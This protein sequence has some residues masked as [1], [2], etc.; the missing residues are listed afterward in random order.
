MIGSDINLSLR[1]IWQ[2]WFNFRKGK[3]ATKEL[4][5]FQFYLEKNIFDLQCDLKN[6]TYC[7]GSYRVFTVCDN[8][9]RV[10]S[11]AP[12]RDRIVH[13]L[14]Y[15]Y[16]VPIFD[17]TFIF[18]AWSCRKGKGLLVC[19]ERTQMF[20]KKNPHS[21]VWR[22][23]IRKFFD[24]VNQEILFGLVFRKVKCSKAQWL[25]RE[26][27]NSFSKIQRERERE[28]FYRNADRQPHQPNIRQYL[29]ERTG[30]FCKT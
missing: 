7:H 16:L 4:H 23:D 11:V 22:A 12:I 17:K 2:S 8:K 29:S 25:I 13:R 15:D 5:E 18:D 1:N 27:V 9:K 6:G 19:I 21:Y 10:I 3:R 30:S 14:I 24:S 28:I 26:V 20:L